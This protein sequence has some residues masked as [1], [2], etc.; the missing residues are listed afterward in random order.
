VSGADD[1]NQ[2]QHRYNQAAL[3][4]DPPASTAR[5]SGRNIPV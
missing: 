1:A 4:P 3:E 2:A 5:R